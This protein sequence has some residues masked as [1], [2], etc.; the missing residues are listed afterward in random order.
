MK[1][2][3]KLLVI[4]SIGFLSCKKSSS[5]VSNND[6]YTNWTVTTSGTPDNGY[7]IQ[8]SPN[9]TEWSGAEWG[10]FGS[11]GVN[12]I[13]SNAYKFTANNTPDD[14]S[15]IAIEFASKPTVPGQYHLSGR[16]II[17]G[18]CHLW[19][20]GDPYWEYTTTDFNQ[21]VNV[22]VSGGKVTISFTDISLSAHNISDG[23][24]S[25]AKISGTLY[26]GH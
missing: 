14:V 8:R 23:S 22:N 17:A 21:T 2:V 11:F 19:F 1:T 24:N 7:W 20:N 26:E 25:T 4:I 12:T 13:S 6:N 16:P 15:Q 18:K 9:G 5:S 10:A 3:I